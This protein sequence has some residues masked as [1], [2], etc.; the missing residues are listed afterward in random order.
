MVFNVIKLLSPKIDLIKS[1]GWLLML[2]KGVLATNHFGN[3]SFLRT[4]FGK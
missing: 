2:H 4:Q 1:A 3:N